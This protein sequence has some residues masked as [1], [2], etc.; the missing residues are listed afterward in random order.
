[1]FKL[2]SYHFI[3]GSSTD[4]TPHH[5]MEE[6][7]FLNLTTQL[8]FTLLSDDPYKSVS[9]AQ[10]RCSKWYPCLENSLWR[11]MLRAH[12]GAR[13]GENELILSLPNLFLSQLWDV[14]QQD[15]TQLLSLNLEATHLLSIG[16][17]ICPA[18]PDYEPINTEICSLSSWAEPLQ[19]TTELLSRRVV[20]R[21]L[22]RLNE[23]MCPSLVCRATS[24]SEKV[25]TVLKRRIVC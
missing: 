10:R 20:V 12:R 25:R 5:N 11:H 24:F 3:N 8:R 7:L 4:K 17:I 13:L 23:R 6:R 2:R 1:M 22:L 15:S 18:V 19:L 14:V 21:L 9:V 16:R